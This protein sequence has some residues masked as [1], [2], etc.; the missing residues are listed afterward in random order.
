MKE[1]EE[2]VWSPYLA[3]ALTGL[4]IIVSVLFT[5]I[6]FGTSTS[7]I[8][9]VAFFEKILA[10]SHF[11]ATLYFSRY[12]PK[13]DWQVMFV[14]GIFLGALVS[15]LTSGSFRWQAVPDRWASSFGRGET[16]RATAAFAGG[17]VTMLGARLAGG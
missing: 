6:Y 7:F 12:A 13:I 2:R 17:V 15:S 9:V 4:L 8:R 16:K 11:A 10:P 3:G 14:V 5:G 1:L